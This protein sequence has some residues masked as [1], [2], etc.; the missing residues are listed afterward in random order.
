MLKLQT[1]LLGI[2]FLCAFVEGAVIPALWTPLRVDLVLGMVLGAVVHLG[3]GQGLLFVML[4]S[5]LLQSFTSARPGLLPLFYLVFFVAIDMLKEVIYLENPLT[6]ALFV[7]GFSVMGTACF[8]L[9]QGVVP[10]GFE[11]V[12]MLAGCLLTGCAGPVM[13]GFMGRLKKV[14]GT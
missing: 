10:Q 9:V 8:F 14:Y 1:S 2:V 6:Q 4:S 5:M 13:V 7:S 12:S 3:F 11:V